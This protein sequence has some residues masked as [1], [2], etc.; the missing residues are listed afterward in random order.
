MAHII[1][2]KELALTIRQELAVHV[3]KLKAERGIT[4][5]LAAVLVGNDPASH[6]Y[7]KNKRAACALA[8]IESFAYDIPSTTTEAKLLALI[9]KLNRDTRVHGILVQLPLPDHV[10]EDAVV[11]AVSPA[12]DVDCFHPTNVGKLSLGQAGLLPCTPAGIIA[13]LDSIG[14]DLN[15]KRAVVIGRSNI[16]GKPT[17]LLLLRHHATVT[18]CH[19]RTIDLATEVGR[20]DVVVAAVGKA[21]FVR[22]E[23]IKPG[24]VVI[25]VG[26]N[27]LPTGIFVGDVDFDEAVKRASAITPVPGGVGPMTIAMLLKNVV[28]AAKQT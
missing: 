2:G 27:R 1:D 22:G 20:A 13:L 3:A 19:S 18:I 5:G 7:V 24:A 26:M 12:K 25:D 9:E 16:V 8:G 10:D 28:E 4:P 14:C 23:W 17:A 11:R 6:M 15:G 21:T